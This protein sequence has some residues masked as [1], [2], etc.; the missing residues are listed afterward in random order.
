MK[1]LLS[2]T[3]AKHKTQY[4]VILKPEKGIEEKSVFNFH[5]FLIVFIFE[6]LIKYNKHICIWKCILYHLNLQN[7][8]NFQPNLKK[9]E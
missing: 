2:T 7:K 6:G 4:S 9:L 3:G 1:E 5:S 8:D